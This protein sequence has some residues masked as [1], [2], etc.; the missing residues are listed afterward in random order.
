VK[1]LNLIEMKSLHP[2]QRVLIL[3]GVLFIYALIEVLIAEKR[4]GH[5][6]VNVWPLLS[7]FGKFAAVTCGLFVPLTLVYMLILKLKK[8]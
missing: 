4:L 7:W 1:E 8:K 5:Q 6:Q 3:C 2:A